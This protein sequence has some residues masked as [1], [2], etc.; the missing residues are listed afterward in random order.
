MCSVS[1]SADK[2]RPRHQ[3]RSVFDSP[4]FENTVRQRL[5]GF[6][7][8]MR[9]LLWVLLSTLVALLATA[10]AASSKIAKFDSY[11]K[12]SPPSAD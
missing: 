4:V 3:K 1:F 9:L 6:R 10:D 8:I 11:A 7:S 5:P 2:L 12:M